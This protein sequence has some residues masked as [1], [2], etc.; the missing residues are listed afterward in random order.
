[1]PARTPRGGKAQ[2]TAPEGTKFVADALAD[3][4]RAYRD[5]SR[6][7]QADVAERMQKLGQSWRRV[8][9]SEVERGRRNVTVVEL[10]SLA[11]LFGVTIGELLDPRRPDQRSVPGVMMLTIGPGA[12]KTP[13]IM[14]SNLLAA[15][16][17][18]H[19]LSIEPADFPGEGMVGFSFKRIQ[20]DEES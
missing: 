16:M 13:P 9:V 20:G 8:T 7:E 11:L 6:L 5:L 17:C 4:I 15:L 19:T 14:P 2:E 1:V 12:E 3:N 18:R 10:L